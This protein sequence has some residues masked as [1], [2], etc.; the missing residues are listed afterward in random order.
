M[1][2]DRGLFLNISEQQ[3]EVES[4]DLTNVYNHV[5]IEN[6]PTLN[7][8]QRARSSL[9]YLFEF[10]V[11]QIEDFFRKWQDFYNEMINKNL[12][13]AIYIKGV[14][15]ICRFEIIQIHGFFCH[16]RSIEATIQL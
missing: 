1:F 6:I 10:F 12:N 9:I 13:I 16:L 5:I 15:K 2:C 14:P 4:F 3:L 7:T 8:T 11:V